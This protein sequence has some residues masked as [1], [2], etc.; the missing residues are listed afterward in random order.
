M[1]SVAYCSVF[2]FVLTKN[3]EVRNFLYLCSSYTVAEFLGTLVDFH[4][5]TVLIQIAEKFM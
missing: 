5:D 3:D 4:T 1:K 2:Y